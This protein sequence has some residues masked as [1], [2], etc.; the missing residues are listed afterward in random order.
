[1]NQRAQA[2]KRTGIAAMLWIVTLCLVP[3]MALATEAT[4]K[5][6]APVPISANAADESLLPAHAVQS[7]KAPDIDIAVKRQL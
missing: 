4:D 3:G 2:M 1:M 6:A 7:I 5:K